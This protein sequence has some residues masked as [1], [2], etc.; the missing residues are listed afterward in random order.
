MIK[1]KK[2]VFKLKDNGKLKKGE[3]KNGD[4]KNRSFWF[5]CCRESSV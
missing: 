4:K 5:R 2:I 1:I 3:R